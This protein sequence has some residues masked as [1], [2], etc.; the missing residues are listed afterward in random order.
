MRQPKLYPVICPGCKA[1]LARAIEGTEVKCPEC[2]E[3]AIAGGE[4]VPRPG[5]KKT[6]ARKRPKMEQLT[7]FG[8]PPTPL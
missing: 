6:K 5:R 7:L 1:E 8:E 2:Y 4:W 3:W